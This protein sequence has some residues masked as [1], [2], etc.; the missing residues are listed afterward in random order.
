MPIIFASSFMMF[1]PSNNVSFLKV[2][3]DRRIGIWTIMGRDS[4]LS[5]YTYNVLYMILIFC[6]LISGRRFSFS[7]EIWQKICVIR[8]VLFRVLGLGHRTAEYLE[9]VMTRITYFGAAF[10]AIIAVVPSAITV[11]LDINWQ[12]HRFWAAQVC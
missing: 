4:W 10:L 5:A 2:H 8:V 1:L 11:L 12:S 9:T 6:S 7:P 3:F